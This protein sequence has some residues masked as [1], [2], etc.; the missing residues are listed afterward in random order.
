MIEFDHHNHVFV[1]HVFSELGIRKTFICV[2]TVVEPRSD[3]L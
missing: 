1:A 2:E 3:M